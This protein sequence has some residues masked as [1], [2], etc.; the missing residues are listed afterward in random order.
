MFP[1]QNLFNEN[2]IVTNV[3]GFTGNFSVDDVLPYQTIPG[4]TIAV[5]LLDGMQDSWQQRCMINH[6]PVSIPTEYAMVTASSK[7]Q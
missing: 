4:G 2:I 7:R 6:V 1:I 3:N 5:N